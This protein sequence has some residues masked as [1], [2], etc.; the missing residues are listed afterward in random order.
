MAVSIR[1]NQTQ[2]SLDE[3]ASYIKNLRFK[4]V[5]IGGIDRASALAAIQE[6]YHMFSQAYEDLAGRLS[7]QQ[8]LASAMRDKQAALE[9]E[10]ARLE[11]EKDSMTQ[12]IQRQMENSN[13]AAATEDKYRQRQAEALAEIDALRQKLQTQEAEM[14]SMQ[15]QH[16]RE[17]EL[18]Q[19]GAADKGET[20]EEIYLEARRSRTEM[21]E[22]AQK[23]AEEMLQKAE[24]EAAAKQAAVDR[25]TAAKR[26]A[27]AQELAD[28]QS[29]AERDAAARRKATEKDLADKRAAAEQE[30]ADKRTA[31]EQLVADAE[32]KAAQI[33]QQAEAA[34]AENQQQCAER[35]AQ[36]RKLVDDADEEA[37]RI[38][39]TAKAT[40]QQE[41][42]KYDAL[43]LRLSALRAKTIQDIQADISS[44]NELVFGVTGRGIE[45][46]TVNSTGL[47]DIDNG[48]DAPEEEDSDTFSFFENILEPEDGAADAQS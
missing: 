26:K 40:Y 21:I 33:R 9:Q 41:R 32:A 2:V 6:I 4:S 15:K 34:D 13:R 28:Q 48:N 11:A 24:R 22:G 45:T 47:A 46:D 30:L 31:A 42:K 7:R 1:D 29:A 27:V 14:V 36:A 20:L 3:I 17:L 18:A 43:L 23:T 35:E 37:K 38:I 5:A 44:L 12:T 25:E 10:V 19:A 16:Q 39:E 8:S